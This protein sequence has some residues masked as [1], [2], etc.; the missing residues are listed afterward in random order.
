MDKD[1]AVARY[2]KLRDMYFIGEVFPR[3][4]KVFQLGNAV[5]YFGAPA[6]EAILAAAVA[7]PQD[8]DLVEICGWEILGRQA[9]NIQCGT[10]KW[11]AKQIIAGTSPL[12]GW[13]PATPVEFKLQSAF[14]AKPFRR[15]WMGSPAGR[16]GLR[17]L[18][19]A[20]M[21]YC[22]NFIEAPFPLCGALVD[23]IFEQLYKED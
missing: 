20:A 4:G 2:G 22:S 21:A 7:A 17:S 12:C 14:S 5:D 15:L 3:L 11:A 10:A 23:E 9:I 18:L 1:T 13:S 16:D 8:N 19:T 6:Y